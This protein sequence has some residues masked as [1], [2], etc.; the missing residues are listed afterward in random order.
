MG[1]TAMLEGGRDDSVGSER[2]VVVATERSE[3]TMGGLGMA[4]ERLER[5]ENAEAR[6]QD[7]SRWGDISPPRPR[8]KWRTNT[9][10]PPTLSPPTPPLTSQHRR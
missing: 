8:R 5:R 3:E 4:G 2:S 7:I 6:K 9:S 1:V 10:D